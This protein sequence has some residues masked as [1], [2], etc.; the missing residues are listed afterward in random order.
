LTTSCLGAGPFG[1]VTTGFFDSGDGGFG[2]LTAGVVGVELVVVV[3]VGAAAEAAACVTPADGA[4]W[5]PG[6]LELPQALRP[7]A[8]STS[9]GVRRRFR[10]IAGR[11]GSEPV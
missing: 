7:V 8:S 11:E 5:T 3:G 1:T 4:A 9:T 6:A 10:R 2:V